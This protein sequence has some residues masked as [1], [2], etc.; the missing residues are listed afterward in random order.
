MY[1]HPGAYE[2]KYDEHNWKVKHNEIIETSERDRRYS[3]FC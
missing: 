3:A 2:L 1:E